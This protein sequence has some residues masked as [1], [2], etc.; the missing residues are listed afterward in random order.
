MMQIERE[1]FVCSFI[2]ENLSLSTVTRFFIAASI[3][4]TK[5]LN[6]TENFRVLLNWGGGQLPPPTSHNFRHCSGR[7]ALFTVTVMF[8]W[9]VCM[10]RILGS[11]GSL[12]DDCAKD[13]SE[14]R[15]TK[16][17]CVLRSNSYRIDKDS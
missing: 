9:F 8:G 13:G 2:I 16:M 7:S 10:K 12:V 1:H 6:S 17:H 15:F 5:F 3:P 14:E 4:T 11:T